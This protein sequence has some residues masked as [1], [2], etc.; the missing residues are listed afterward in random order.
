[1]DITGFITGFAT[2]VFGEIN[3]PSVL[4]RVVEFFE[5]NSIIT[6]VIFAVS[7]FIL[8]KLVRMA[9]TIFLVVI[10]GLIFP[11]AMNLVLG[12]TIPITVST[13]IFYA[14]LAAVFYLAA[15]FIKGLLKFL[16]VVTGPLRKSA[17]RKELEEDIK[18]D[19]EEERRK[20]MKKYMKRKKK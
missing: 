2:K 4:D 8:Y 3:L 9:F 5:T 7:I 6:F 19:L 20:R 13:L 16:Y 15:V 18:E 12:W 17:E 11:F 1:M 10:A 14:T